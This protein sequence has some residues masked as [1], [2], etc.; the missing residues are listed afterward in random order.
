MEKPAN[1]AAQKY[2]LEVQASS[3]FGFLKQTFS[4]MPRT[5]QVIGWLVILMLFAFLV[6]YPL[7][8]ITY[9]QGKIVPLSEDRNAKSL[10]KGVRVSK[11]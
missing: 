1:D 9:L 6:L 3:L 11:R 2:S 4:Q 5:V 8:G 7:L 10:V